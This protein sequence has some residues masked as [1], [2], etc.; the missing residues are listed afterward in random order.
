MGK[1]TGIYGNSPA[2][3]QEVPP[4][5]RI[6][7]F[8]EFHVPLHPDEQQAPGRPVYGL[9]RSL[10]PERHDAGRHGQWLPPEQP[11]SRVE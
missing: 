6:E 9:R 5:E 1:N 4:L 8:Q 2:D 10:L 7:H 3:Q 11:D